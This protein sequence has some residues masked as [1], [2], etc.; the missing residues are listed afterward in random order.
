MFLLLLLLHLL[1]PLLLLLR[2]VAPPLGQLV[3]LHQRLPLSLMRRSANPKVTLSNFSTWSSSNSSKSTSGIL[4]PPPSVSMPRRTLLQFERP[5][6]LCL[7]ARW[8]V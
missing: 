7:S 4:F 8:R 5:A 6:P 1:F 2:K 3:R